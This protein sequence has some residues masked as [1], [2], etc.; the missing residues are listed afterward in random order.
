MVLRMERL[1]QAM[2]PN[3]HAYYNIMPKFNMIKN[4]AAPTIMR[5]AQ[6]QQSIISQIM[7]QIE[8]INK[9]REIYNS[10]APAN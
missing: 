9:Q 2:F 5:L 10:I 3:I 1:S 6:Q 4:I 7:P 8:L